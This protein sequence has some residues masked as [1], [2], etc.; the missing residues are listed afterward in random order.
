MGPKKQRIH[1][2]SLLKKQKFNQ[3]NDELSD[4]IKTDSTWSISTC[5][6]NISDFYRIFSIIRMIIFLLAVD[7][8]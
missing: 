2:N 3:S 1:L 7:A 6:L 5:D 8:Y 4:D